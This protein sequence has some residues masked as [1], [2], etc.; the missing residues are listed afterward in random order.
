MTAHTFDSRHYPAAVVEYGKPEINPLQSLNTG[1]FRKG[2]SMECFNNKNKH[3]KAD[4]ST[5]KNLIYRSSSNTPAFGK[6]CRLS[7]IKKIIPLR[8]FNKR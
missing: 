5:L 6:V 7:G 4:P 3:L 2:Q 1:Y 8:G